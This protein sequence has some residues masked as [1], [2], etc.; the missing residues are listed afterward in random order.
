M[1]TYKS[2]YSGEEWYKLRVYCNNG[3]E[4]QGFETLEEAKAKAKDEERQWAIFHD[5]KNV[6]QN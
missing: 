6:A 3:Y 2:V 4:E 1:A 5:G